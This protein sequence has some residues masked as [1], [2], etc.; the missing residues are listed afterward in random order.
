M[1]AYQC[2]CPEQPLLPILVKHMRGGREFVF[3]HCVFCKM[4]ATW[5]GGTEEE[6]KQNS[7][8]KEVSEGEIKPKELEWYRKKTSK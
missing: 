8:V 2:G 5:M 7:Y 6:V 3:T 4:N 1:L